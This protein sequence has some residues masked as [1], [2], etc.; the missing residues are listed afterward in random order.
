MSATFRR[1]RMSRVVSIALFP[2][3]ISLGTVVRRQW[4]FCAEI[5]GSGG[6]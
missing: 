6:P 3:A 1:P 5:C 4:R 2:P